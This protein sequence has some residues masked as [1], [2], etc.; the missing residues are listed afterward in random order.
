MD[1]LLT[2][3]VSFVCLFVR[4]RIYPSKINLKALNCAQRFIG[5]QGRESPILGTFAPPEAPQKSKI[6]RIGPRAGRARWSAR[7]PIRP[8]R[9]PRVGSACVDMRPS[10]MTDVL[11]HA[12]PA[13]WGFIFVKIF[14]MSTLSAPQRSCRPLCSVQI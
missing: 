14:G 3:C 4:L 2:V 7:W 12:S 8:A 9:W 13:W 6:G 5:V 11:I 10:P 1:I